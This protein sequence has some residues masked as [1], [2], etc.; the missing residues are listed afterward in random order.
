MKYLNGFSF[1][2][3]PV[4]WGLA[5]IN[6]IIFTI[7]FLINYNYTKNYSNINRILGFNFIGLVPFIFYISI[8]AILGF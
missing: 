5:L 4:I 6:Y 8:I 2:S 7:V 3:S 1:V